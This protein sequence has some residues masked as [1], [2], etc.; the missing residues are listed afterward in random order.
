MPTR[1]RLIPIRILAVLAVAALLLPVPAPDGTGRAR[2]LRV[3]ARQFAFEP[4]SLRVN[5][6]DTVTLELQAL[7]AI[8]GL[9]LDGYG[10]Q[11]KAEPGHLA[12]ATF[13]A[14]RAGKF[15]FRCSVSC[16]TLHPFMIGELRVGTNWPF[17]RALAAGGL[18]LAAAMLF[19]WRR[20]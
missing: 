13:V 15:K 14:G 3:D 11:L 5:Q 17:A 1:T 7:D 12:R 10:V 18:A 6:G 4:A 9:Y 20:A 19:S 8:H 16:G 2:V